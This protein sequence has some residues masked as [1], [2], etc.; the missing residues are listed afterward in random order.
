VT[1]VESSG[2]ESTPCAGGDISFAGAPLIA[3]VVGG[4]ARSWLVW[5]AFAAAAGE[6]AR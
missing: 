5:V 2:G 1:L 6:S 3:A 4:G